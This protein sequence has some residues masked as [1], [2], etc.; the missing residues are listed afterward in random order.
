[1]NAKWFA[2]YL[3]CCALLSINAVF[4][5]NLYL[6][7]FL[8]IVWLVNWNV[9]NQ[10]TKQVVDNALTIKISNLLLEQ[11]YI[12]KLKYINKDKKEEAVIHHEKMTK[13]LKLIEMGSEY[14]FWAK[15][16]GIPQ[17]DN[18]L[19]WVKTCLILGRPGNLILS[20]LDKNK[21]KEN[22]I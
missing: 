3:F 6:R 13:A 15:K 2:L 12:A 20:Y 14:V 8:I 22:D 19:L 16:T 21:I 1:M 17:I 7:V 10:L 4:A 9:I 11:L 5:N 18:E